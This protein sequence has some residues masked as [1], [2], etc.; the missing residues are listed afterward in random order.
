M[1]LDTDRVDMR[2]AT[3]R[4]HD[5]ASGIVVVLTSLVQL[6]A[7]VVE[8]VRN[9]ASGMLANNDDDHDH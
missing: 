1:P 6:G 7:K 5:I 8:K 3:Y 2:A 4:V 9:M